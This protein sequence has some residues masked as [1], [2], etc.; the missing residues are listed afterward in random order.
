MENCMIPIL[1]ETDI[2]IDKCDKYFY[3]GKPVPRV[4]E[5]LSRCIH[6]DALMN[7][8]NSLGFKHKSYKLTLEEAATIGSIVHEAIEKYLADETCLSNEF[9]FLAF[10]KWWDMIHTNNEIKIIGSEQELVCPWFGGT[11]DMLIEINGKLWLVD[12]KTSNHVTMNYFLQLAA[13]RYILWTEYGIQLQGAIILQ[14]NKYE[15]SFQEYVLDFSIISHYEFIEH[16]T[17]TFLSLVYAYYNLYKT[18]TT[19]KQYMKGAL[20]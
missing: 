11:Y 9:G 3:N 16:C 6:N 7:W 4:T 12:F 15:V 18:E 13:Y 10:K 19:F 8:A 20:Q 17:T 5:I 1:K 14:L 2:I